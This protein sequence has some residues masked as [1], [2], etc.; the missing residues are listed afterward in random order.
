MKNA[1]EV[2]TDYLLAAASWQDSL[3]QSYR[4]LHITIQSILLPASAG[5]FVAI[6]SLESI[7][8][9]VVAFIA[10][11]FMWILQKFTADKFKPIILNRGDDVNFWH[12]EII[13]AE[14]KLAPE[15]RFFTKF[16]VY[17]KLHREGSDYLQNTFLSTAE[18]NLQDV[19]I[20][21]EKGLG[22][23]RHAI[24]EQLFERISIIWNVF[25]LMSLLIILYRS[26]NE[27]IRFW[28]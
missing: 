27:I 25:T 8:G 1:D 2:E 9:A 15:R 13:M 20:L 23:T 7:Y 26:Y 21:I 17:Q 18:I 19:D 4:S 22:H 14:Q 11:V 24:D 3:L 5:L 12:R 6:V 10:M 28:L 16:K